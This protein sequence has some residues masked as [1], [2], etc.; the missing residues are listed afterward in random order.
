MENSLPCQEITLK[1][2][3][4]RLRIYEPTTCMSNSVTTEVIWLTN[5]SDPGHTQY[6]F[7]EKINNMIIKQ[8]I[9]V[10]SVLQLNFFN[11]KILTKSSHTVTI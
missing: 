11:N 8:F 3:R 10:Q 4:L 6:Q 5:V 2:N 7:L 9:P 1:W